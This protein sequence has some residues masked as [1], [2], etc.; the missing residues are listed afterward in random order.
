MNQFSNHASQVLIVGGG[1]VGLATRLE[2]ACRRDE[3]GMPA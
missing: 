2:L 3:A 1:P